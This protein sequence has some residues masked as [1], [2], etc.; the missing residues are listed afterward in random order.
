MSYQDCMWL[1]YIPI[2]NIFVFESKIDELLKQMKIAKKSYKIYFTSVNK[3]LGCFSNK[4]GNTWNNCLILMLWLASILNNHLQFFTC[5]RCWQNPIIRHEIYDENFTFPS[6]F[7]LSMYYQE[8][9]KWIKCFHLHLHLPSHLCWIPH[10]TE[11]KTIQSRRSGLNQ[12]FRVAQTTFC[13]LF[14]MWNT[15]SIFRVSDALLHYNR[16][17][18]PKPLSP[19]FLSYLK[20]TRWLFIGQWWLWS[21]GVMARIYIIFSNI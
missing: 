4:A 15:F 16:L 13:T 20:T 21:V 14:V 17:L 18:I 1:Q 7:I 9:G 5:K 19:T 6:D 10:V 2:S 8:I 12:L 3:T 11:P